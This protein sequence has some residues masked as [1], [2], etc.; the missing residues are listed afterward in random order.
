[1]TQTFASQTGYFLGLGR[2]SIYY[3]DGSSSM[4]WRKLQDNIKF[5]LPSDTLFYG[6][7]YQELK[8]EGKAQ[9]R[10]TA[11]DI[12]DVLFLGGKDVRN[13]IFTRR[14]LMASKLVKAVT[15]RTQK[16]YAS[17]RVKRVYNL[18]SLQ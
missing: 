8:G 12:I 7:I 9:R 2:Q 6:E 18:T 1:V 10:T 17:L 3:W 5:E 15:K 13:E 16:E 11:V 14:M 4:K